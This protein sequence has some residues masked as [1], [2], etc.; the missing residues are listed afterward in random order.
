MRDGAVGNGKG[1]WELTLHD[2][3]VRRLVF[4]R[5]SV[6][7]VH[8]PR[9]MAGARCYEQDSRDE[10]GHS[11]RILDDGDKEEF[12]NVP[13]I[14]ISLKRKPHIVHLDYSHEAGETN[15]FQIWVW[16]K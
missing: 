9:K 3:V 2:M 6:R 8:P 13:L 4:A 14:S 5:K 12:T 7:H 1:M 10:D 15:F 16:G 11:G